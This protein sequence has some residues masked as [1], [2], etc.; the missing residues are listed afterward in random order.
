MWK[1]NEWLNV[2]L[3]HTSV[4]FLLHL[5]PW[6]V[7]CLL[8]ATLAGPAA[9]ASATCPR[10]LAYTNITRSIGG[11]LIT[12]TRSTF[13]I[14]HTLLYY[15]HQYKNEQFSMDTFLSSGGRSGWREFWKRKAKQLIYLRW[16]FSYEICHYFS[17]RKHETNLP[18]PLK[19]T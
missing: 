19:C 12:W 17:F 11:F 6:H 13:H 10:Q 9:G 14:L 4:S 1:T 3:R 8:R 18:S 15:Y 7:T 5:C 2:A 16:K